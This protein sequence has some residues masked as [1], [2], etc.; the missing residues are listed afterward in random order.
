MIRGGCRPNTPLGGR[1]PETAGYG[2]A[3]QVFLGSLLVHAGVLHGFVSIVFSCVSDTMSHRV[4]PRRRQAVQKGPHVSAT[5][6]QWPPPSVLESPGE[7]RASSP[8]TAEHP[9]RRA[10]APAPKLF[11]VGM[12]LHTTLSVALLPFAGRKSEVIIGAAA[13]AA[14]ANAFSTRL[15]PGPSSAA[16]GVVY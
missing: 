12:P 8:P 1:R 2:S 6:P 13:E 9:K 3:L 7:W 15:R 14:R 16:E 4:G 5:Y 11:E 10:C